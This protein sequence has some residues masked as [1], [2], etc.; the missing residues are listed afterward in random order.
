MLLPPLWCSTG[1]PSP[2]S[3]LLLCLVRLLPL[4]KV[5]GPQP[6]TGPMGL[7]PIK[8]WTNSVCQHSTSFS[9]QPLEVSV[10]GGKYRVTG[11]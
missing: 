11:K 1:C 5:A 10:L 4:H 8:W 6:E 3:S 9:F 2:L 7:G